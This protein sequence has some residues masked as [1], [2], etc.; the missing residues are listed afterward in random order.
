MSLNFI[1]DYNPLKGLT[2][3]QISSQTFSLYFHLN[4]TV[5]IYSTFDTNNIFNKCFL[6]I[7]IG[8]S[9]LCTKRIP[10]H[11]KRFQA[12]FNQRIATVV[13]IFSLR[14]KSILH[15]NSAVKP[16]RRPRFNVPV[17]IRSRTTVPCYSIIYSFHVIVLADMRILITVFD[18]I[19]VESYRSKTSWS[20]HDDDQKLARRNEVYQ[21][22]KA[23]SIWGEEYMQSREPSLSPR[24]CIHPC[25]S[26]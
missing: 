24:T 23:R 17:F 20:A 21:Q 6:V 12:K 26:R 9:Y 19:Y 10:D 1:N 2:C 14:F 7:W 16:E 22:T 11:S 25:L 18:S 13:A 5:N 15:F 3:V 4:Q 8:I